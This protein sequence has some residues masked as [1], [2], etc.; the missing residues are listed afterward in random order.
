M[1]VVAEGA[2]GGDIEVAPRDQGR[3]REYGATKTFADYH[4]VRSDSVVLEREHAA[5][6]AEA[7][8]N[9]VQD[10]KRAVPVA[11]IPHDVVVLGR[12]YLD[13]GRAHRLDDHRADVFLFCENIVDVFSA[14]CIACCAA[15]EA[16]RQRIARR[17]ML[18]A[19]EEG[20][21]S[22]A[23]DGFTADRYRVERRAVERVPER[24]RFVAPG[25]EPGALQG[26]TDGERTARSEQDLAERVG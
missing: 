5:G 20:A 3:H 6:A 4:H 7:D 16:A 23:E 13:V 17:R 22:L 25:R 11:S 15:A 10:Q 2:F 18:R 12:G 26:H 1:R 14:S 19:G 21:D 9:L 24:E 8:R